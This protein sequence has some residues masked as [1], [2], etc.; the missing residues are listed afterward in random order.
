MFAFIPLKSEKSLNKLPYVTIGL[1]VINTIILMITGPLAKKQQNEMAELLDKMF[2]IEFQYLDENYFLDPEVIQNFD[3]DQHHEEV[4]SGHIIP[5]DSEDYLQWV[6]LH[7]RYL[8]KKE[9]FV[10]QRWGLIPSQFGFLKILTSMF[11][12]A[13]LL[14]LLGNML[15]LWTV[16]ANMEDRVGATEFSVLYIVSG[17]IAA[18]FHKIAFPASETPCIGASGAVSG[19]M[20]AFLIN[21]YRTKI[22]GLFT[23][24]FFYWRALSLPAYV[25]LPFFFLKEIVEAQTSQSFGVAHW[26]HIGGFVLGAGIMVVYRSTGLL[27]KVEHFDDSPQYNAESIIGSLN[28]KD[29]I[30]ENHPDNRIVPY[31]RAT[32][33][34]PRDAAAWLKLSRAYNQFG[35]QEDAARSYNQTVKLIVEDSQSQYVSAT[36]HDLIS[37][38]LMEKLHK[39]QLFDLANFLYD[40]QKYK[41]AVRLFSMYVK[42]FPNAIYRPNAIHKIHIILSNHIQNGEMARRAMLLLKKEYPD[43]NPG[44]N[45]L[46]F[47]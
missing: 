28:K 10:F 19:I 47:D 24:G 2:S 26:A 4:R 37:K 43:Y 30:G 1:I 16:G 34:S 17:V 40:H 39:D 9:Q 27:E 13:G 18:L 42:K 29:H 25:I 36:Y 5:V 31:I 21:Y 15:F 7:D 6:E 23:I 41:S 14:H 3:L 11:L 12:H 35:Y 46:L 38:N 32:R 33:Q 45:S 8:Y 22:R 20:G 44:S